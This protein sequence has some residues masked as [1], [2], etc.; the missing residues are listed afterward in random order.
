MESQE[1][2]QENFQ[3]DFL[4]WIAPQEDEAVRRLEV[5]DALY[6]VVL[7]AEQPEARLGLENGDS[8][9]GEKER[10]KKGGASGRLTDSRRNELPY[11]AAR[12][13]LSSSNSCFVSLRKSKSADLLVW[14]VFRLDARHLLLT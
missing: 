8:W 4:L 11:R 6:Q 14:K 10:E 1:N 13:R 7:E 2:F 12:R 3:E 9:K 5:L